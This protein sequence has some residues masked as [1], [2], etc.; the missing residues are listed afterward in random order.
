MSE[1]VCEPASTHSPSFFYEKKQDTR[2]S[3]CPGHDII[4]VG[5]LEKC[6]LYGWRGMS[7]YLSAPTLALLTLFNL[8]N[9]RIGICLA[10][11]CKK[12]TLII[13][14][15]LGS[16]GERHNHVRRNFPAFHHRMSCNCDCL[17]FLCHESPLPHVKI[18]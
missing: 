16:C 10:I 3:G 12:Q 6:E 11:S 13:A 14:V 7:R 8:P 9:E 2:Y 17:F 4:P 15:N 18:E 1:G 5:I